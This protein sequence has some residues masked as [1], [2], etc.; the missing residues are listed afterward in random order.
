MKVALLSAIAVDGKLFTRGAKVE[1]DE[2]LGEDLVRRGKAQQLAGD[3]PPPKKEAPPTDEPEKG[4][5][6][7]SKAKTEAQDA[8][9]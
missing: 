8:K 5:K 1:V 7:K 3:E 4:D 6:K 9:G 2:M